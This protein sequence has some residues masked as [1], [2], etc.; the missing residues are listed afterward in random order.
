MN[1]CPKKTLPGRVFRK[2]FKFFIFMLIELHSFF[3][4]IFIYSIHIGTTYVIM[5]FALPELLNTKNGTN[6]LYILYGF[7]LLTAERRQKKTV[8]VRFRAKDF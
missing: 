4:N 8:V 1:E 3:V 2:P 5:I 6:W 7:C